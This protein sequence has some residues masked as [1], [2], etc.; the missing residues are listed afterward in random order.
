MKRC[1]FPAKRPERKKIGGY[2][3]VRVP[4][5]SCRELIWIS[6]RIAP[7]LRCLAIC[8]DCLGLR[9]HRTYGNNHPETP[10][11]TQRYEGH[12]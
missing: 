8:E 3:H 9:P 12:P 2:W 1:H 7:C 11:S 4:C 5:R 10:E 6:A